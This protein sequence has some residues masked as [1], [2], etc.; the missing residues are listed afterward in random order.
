VPEFEED[1]SDS[2]RYDDRCGKLQ[3]SLPVAAKWN[4]LISDNLVGEIDWRF[5]LTKF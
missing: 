1:R 4:W 3:N 2:S 5:K